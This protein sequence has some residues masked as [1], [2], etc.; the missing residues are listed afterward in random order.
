MHRARQLRHQ[1]GQLPHQR[2]SSPS[3]ETRR[4]SEMGDPCPPRCTRGVRRSVWD[5]EPSR[6][7]VGVPQGQT[8]SGGEFLNQIFA[9]QKRGGFLRSTSAAK[10][11]GRGR[12][13]FPWHVTRRDERKIGG[14]DTKKGDTSSPSKTSKEGVEPTR[15]EMLVPAPPA[16]TRRHMLDPGRPEAVSPGWGVV[17][18]DLQS[19]IDC[20]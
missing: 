12:A 14:G 10:I 11:R 2:T 16:W 20:Q 19:S 13:P 3:K 6:K 9:E 15:G 4:I 8:E 5:P 1:R 7:R 17:L 18:T